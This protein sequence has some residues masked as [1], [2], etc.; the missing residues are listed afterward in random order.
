M[1]NHAG[2]GR[3]RPDPDGLG[4]IQPDR[5]M[6]DHAE[7]GRTQPDR[8][9]SRRTGSRRTQRDRTMPDHA[10]LG[11]IQPDRA[12]GSRQTQPDRTKPDGSELKWIRSDRTRTPLNYLAATR[13]SS[14]RWRRRSTRREKNGAKI[15]RKTGWP[16]RV[17]G[18]T[19]SPS[20]A[21]GFITWVR[22]VAPGWLVRIVADRRRSCRFND[23][24][25]S[26]GA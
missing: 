17:F 19:K 14:S 12:A 9:G 16:S 8:T 4:R 10:E 6:P 5:T 7:L 11:R 15:I 25:S 23:I 3:S 24:A 20:P 26:V 1:P 21:A 2:P 13:S 18:E 22:A